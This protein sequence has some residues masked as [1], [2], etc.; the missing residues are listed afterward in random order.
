M[1]LL[2]CYT[3][4]CFCAPPPTPWHVREAHCPQSKTSILWC[5][6]RVPCFPAAKMNPAPWCSVLKNFRDRI[7]ARLL[8]PHLP[9]PTPAEAAFFRGHFILAPLGIPPEGHSYAPSRIAFDYPLECMLVDC[10]RRRVVCEWYWCLR[11]QSNVVRVC[12]SAQTRHGNEAELRDFRLL[13]TC[14]RSLLVPACSRDRRRGLRLRRG[15][16][17]NGKRKTS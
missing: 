1:A 2:C 4:K 14:S 16:P 6:P 17:S 8:A 9:P 12:F 11:V 13:R 15:P 7:T 3:I 5:C 10:A